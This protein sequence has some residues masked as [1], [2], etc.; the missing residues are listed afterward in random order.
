MGYLREKIGSHDVKELTRSDVI[1]AQKVNSHRT[2]FANYIPQMLVV[3]CEHGID[4][5]WNQSDPA[6]GVRALKIP[7]ERQRE[8]LPWPD[9]PWKNSGPKP[10]TSAA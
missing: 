7:T 10:A 3:L 5:G 9:W 4:L 8:H 1:G 2:C 6:K